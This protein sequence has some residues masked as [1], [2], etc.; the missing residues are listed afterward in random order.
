M[1]DTFIGVVASSR[2]AVDRVSMTMEQVV[3]HTNAELSTVASSNVVN[4]LNELVDAA[5]NDEGSAAAVTAPHDVGVV[6]GG[7]TPGDSDSECAVRDTA[8]TPE[9]TATAQPPAPVIGHAYSQLALLLQ[10]KPD[11]EQT[12]GGTEVLCM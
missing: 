7:T 6:V 9:P 5:D 4:A 8:D 1:L 3:Q 2:N 10:A 12:H 11:W